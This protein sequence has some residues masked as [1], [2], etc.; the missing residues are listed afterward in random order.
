MI[1]DEF[2]HKTGDFPVRKLLLL[3]PW[4]L[5]LVQSSPDNSD[6]GFPTIFPAKNPP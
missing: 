4:A 3:I 6:M 2:T 1:Y 5:Q